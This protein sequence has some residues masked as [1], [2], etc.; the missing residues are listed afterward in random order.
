MFSETMVNTTIA[1]DKRVYKRLQKVKHKL[2]NKNGN[3]SFN[4]TVDH[5][6]DV[7]EKYG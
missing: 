4:K 3:Y 2:E 6:L 7:E 5:L 1:L